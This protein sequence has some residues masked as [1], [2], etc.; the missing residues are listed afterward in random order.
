MRPRYSARA[1]SAQPGSLLATDATC[2]RGTIGL[3]GAP[4]RGGLLEPHFLAAPDF[5]EV[6]VAAHARVHHVHDD[7]AQVGERPY[8]TRGI[9]ACDH[10]ALEDRRKLRDVVDDD[11][12]TFHVLECLDDRALLLTNVHTGDVVG[13]IGVP[14]QE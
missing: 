11:V 9:A 14:V 8:L 4:W 13:C 12:A 7:V 10:D 1:A 3:A 6:V 5:L 2:R